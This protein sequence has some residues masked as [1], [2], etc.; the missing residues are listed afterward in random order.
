MIRAETLAPHGWAI[1]THF[2]TVLH[3]STDCQ[4][5]IDNHQS[6]SHKSE[7]MRMKGRLHCK[8]H[9][10]HTIREHTGRNRAVTEQESGFISQ[11][12]AMT[13][14]RHSGLSGSTRG[15]YAWSLGRLEGRSVT[16]RH[17][18]GGFLG[19]LKLRS[20]WIGGDLVE[21]RQA[22]RLCVTPTGSR[23]GTPRM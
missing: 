17:A 23:K 21:G 4:R 7:V 13:S 20:S 11:P 19:L 15:S 3:L 10:K 12:I 1:I 16:Q 22:Q 6:S 5:P 14:L 9:S 8:L 2:L 18:R